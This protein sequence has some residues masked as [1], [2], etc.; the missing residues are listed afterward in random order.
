MASLMPSLASQAGMW[1]L[2]SCATSVNTL[3]VPVP[4]TGGLSLSTVSAGGTRTCGVTTS[5]SAYCWGAGSAAPVVVTGGLVFRTV[6]VGREHVCGVTTSQVAFCWGSNFY[7]Q[8][9]NGSQ[10]DSSM[11]VKVAGQP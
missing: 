6:S 8:L 9:G 11:P 5:G 2:Q 4:V 1:T 3:S 10:I 7:G